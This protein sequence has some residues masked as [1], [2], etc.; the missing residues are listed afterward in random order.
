MR[1]YYVFAINDATSARHLEP[2]PQPFVDDLAETANEL[3]ATRAWTSAS[4]LFRWRY[5]ETHRINISRTWH[6]AI[7]STHLSGA[8]IVT[9]IGFLDSQRQTEIP[10]AETHLSPNFAEI[11][12]S[13]VAR[14]PRRG[15][16]GRCGAV[17]SS[18]AIG[19]IALAP[20]GKYWPERAT[21]SKQGEHRWQ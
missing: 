11:R 14:M 9:S 21:A 17:N 1:G 18:V 10:N 20:G 7:C 5:D 15:F 16:S 13:W 8:S 12:M 3:A 4:I 2:T 6:F 19:I